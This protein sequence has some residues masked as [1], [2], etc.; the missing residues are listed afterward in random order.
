MLHNEEVIKSEE[1]KEL[2][3]HI[4]NQKE[5]AKNSAFKSNITHT[6]KQTK[7][8]SFKFIELITDKYDIQKNGRKIMLTTKFLFL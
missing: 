7:I 5:R 1:K 4:Q 3:K 8:P 6:N 2:K